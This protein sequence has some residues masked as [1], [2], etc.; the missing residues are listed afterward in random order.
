MSDL[1]TYLRSTPLPLL[2]LLGALPYGVIIADDKGTIC[3]WND[4]AQTQFQ[5]T[6]EETIGKNLVMLMPDKFA[7]AHTEALERRRDIGATGGSAIIGNTVQIFGRRKDGSEFPI[8][9]SVIA[10]KIVDFPAYLAIVCDTSDQQMMLMSKVIF[11]NLA[12]INSRMKELSQ[13][14]TLPPYMQPTQKRE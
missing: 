7:A 6:A 8:E 13:K 2:P 14:I 9:L 10:H 11:E 12:N 3:F 4:G 5:F 1:A